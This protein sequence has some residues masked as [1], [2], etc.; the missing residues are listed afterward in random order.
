MNRVW[1]T[2]AQLYY[3]CRMASSSAARSFSPDRKRPKLDE[4][5][6]TAQANS[7]EP[8]PESDSA[9]TEIVLVLC[10]SMNPITFLHLRMF[11]EFHTCPGVLLVLLPDVFETLHVPLYC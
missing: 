5:V 9:K 7:K 10:G 11:G 8:L 4:S 6:A 2:V 1:S 3:A